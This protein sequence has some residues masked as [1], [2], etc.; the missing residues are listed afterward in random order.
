MTARGV[1]QFSRLVLAVKRVVNTYV[2][3]TVSPDG[4]KGLIG[5]DYFSPPYSMRLLLLL[6][7]CYRLRELGCRLSVIIQVHIADWDLITELLLLTIL[8]HVILS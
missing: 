2:V 5:V 8:L 7:P 6:S 3:L 1:C 4:F